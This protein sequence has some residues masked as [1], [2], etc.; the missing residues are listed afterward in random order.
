MQV[1]VGTDIIEV[2]RIQE[3][4]DEL[5]DKFVNRIFTEKE[6]EYCKNTRASKYQHYAARFAGKEAAFKA[7]S[8]LLSDKY[9]I[10]WKNIQIMND[11][12]GRP[13][14]EFIALSKKVEKELK[15]IISIDISLSHIKD[16][17]IANVTLLIE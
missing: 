9:S 16:Y 12:N 13:S 10:S 2:S 17:A 1:K 14:I 6:I 8:D 5:E 11:E 4:I 15:K 7:V 3:S